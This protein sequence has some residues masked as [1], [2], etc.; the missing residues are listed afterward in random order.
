MALGLGSS[1]V[2]G[3]AS[4]LTFVKDNLKLYLDFKSN[5][6]DTLKFPS[7][8]STSF[9]GDNDYIDFGNDSSLQIT[10]ALSISSWIK[11]DNNNTFMEL[12]SKN[13]NTN[14]NN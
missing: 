5:K 2:K 9:D 8:G 10:G 4:L 12:V 6:S 13:D 7:E 1:L 3:G 14:K 11:T